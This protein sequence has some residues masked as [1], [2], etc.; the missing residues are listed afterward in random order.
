[1]ILTKRLRCYPYGNYL[2]LFNLAGSTLTKKIFLSLPFGPEKTY[3]KILK[4]PRY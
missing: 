1:M 2:L 4:N 3:W